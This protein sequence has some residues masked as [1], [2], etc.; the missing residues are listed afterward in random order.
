MGVALAVLGTSSALAQK[1]EQTKKPRDRVRALVLDQ[2]SSPV[3][4]ELKR[5]Q[6][7]QLTQAA[8]AKGRGNDPSKYDVLIVDGDA[9]SPQ[10]L[11][12]DTL[13]DEFADA[14]RWVLALDVDPADYDQGLVDHTAFTMG[15]RDAKS[16][17]LLFS[18]QLLN[19]MPRVVIIQAQSLQPL[20]PEN[21][22]Q[23]WL[24]Q[25]T[26]RQT[27]EVAST[28]TRALSAG[29][30]T[31]AEEYAP[32]GEE[33]KP[34]DEAQSWH[35]TLSDIGSSAPPYPGYWPGRD[36]ARQCLQDYDPV[37]NSCPYWAD[38][39]SHGDQTPNW[40]FNHMFDVYLDNA[41]NSQGDYQHVTYRLHGSFSPK[42][43]Y[44]PLHPTVKAEKFW[45]MFDPFTI[46][47]W[48][49]GHE[50]SFRAQME[51]AWWTQQLGAEVRPDAQTNAK[52]VRDQ[53][54]PATPNAETHYSTKQTFHVNIT[55]SNSGGGISSDY[56]IENGEDET[57]PDWGVEN[58]GDN[59][60]LYWM[61]SA[62]QPCDL[63]DEVHHT[64][65]CFTTGLDPDAGMPKRPAE[66]SLNE[67]EVD[68]FARWHTRELL[69]GENGKATFRIKTPVALAD[70][71]CTRM[72]LIGCAAFSK[73]VKRG[74]VGT[75]HE[76][77]F[78]TSYGIDIGVVNPIPI[79]SISFA[80][81]PANGE[82]LDKVTGT[83]TLERPAAKN[84]TVVIYSNSENATVGTPITDRVSRGTATIAQGETSGTFQVLTNDNN[85][86]PGDHTTATIT[87]FYTSP[88][89]EQL[90]IVSPLKGSAKP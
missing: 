14:N 13:V 81:N 78:W 36:G 34:P 22:D 55:A 71:A 2:A 29:P 6:G 45:Q 12:E 62:R 5:S 11:G 87:A 8:N 52:L 25:S 74:A 68:A 31:L 64:A 46:Y 28:A 90:R 18:R 19:N 73:E 30:S 50:E 1:Q 15:E 82:K 86:K 88:K 4:A 40:T 80:P 65:D 33:T 60:Q 72:G 67:L 10:Q 54:L 20:L 27:Q 48:V 23:E 61:F 79:R 84:V 44:D 37:H 7:W 39:P 32:R 76:N 89:Q 57:I 21:M 47:Q 56:T 70:T 63:R 35:V 75:N 17:M 59:D 69:S 83:V 41:N 42:R 77:D 51:R 3:L 24:S 26:A 58:K 53:S 9:L 43:N 66:L 16:A 38:I 49:N 85:L